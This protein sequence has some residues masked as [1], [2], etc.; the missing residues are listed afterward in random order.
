MPNSHYMYGVI[1]EIY[2]LGI[3]MKKKFINSCSWGNTFNVKCICKQRACSC[4]F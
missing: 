4:I 1:N 3:I 2:I